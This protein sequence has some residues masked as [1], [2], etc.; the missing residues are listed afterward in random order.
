MLTMVCVSCLVGVTIY[1]MFMSGL[2]RPISL[3]IEAGLASVGAGSLFILI[4]YRK[5]F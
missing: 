1:P 3:M 4:K 5:S 2:G